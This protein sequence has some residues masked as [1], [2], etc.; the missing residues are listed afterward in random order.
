MLLLNA[1]KQ[2]DDDMSGYL[3][4][5]TVVRVLTDKKVSKEGRAEE[6][7]RIKDSIVCSAFEG[8]APVLAASSC[9]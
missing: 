9:L 8:L 1:F 6:M 2:N 4:P 7:P 5:E 3:R